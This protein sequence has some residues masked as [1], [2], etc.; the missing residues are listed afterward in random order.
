MIKNGTEVK[1]MTGKDKGKK[2]QVIEIIRSQNKAK[3]KG[4]N[5]IKK[6]EKTTKEKKGG[7]VTKE[8]FIH[9]SNLK[10]LDTVDSKTKKVGKNNDTKS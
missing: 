10:S 1:I 7:I 6:H 5:F 9:I 3:V 4:I 8:N 2:G